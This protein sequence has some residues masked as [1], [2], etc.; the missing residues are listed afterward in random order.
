M[1]ANPPLLYKNDGEHTVS[2]K[3][4]VG[5]DGFG[6]AQF[7]GDLRQ[8]VSEVPN[9][10]LEARA[11]MADRLMGKPKQ[12][13]KQKKRRIMSKKPSCKGS[14]DEEEEKETA[15][16]TENPKGVES[17]EEQGKKL[18]RV[19]YY[20]NS[21]SIGL[22]EKTGLKR[23]LVSFGGKRLGTEEELRLIADECLIKLGQGEEH[24]SVKAWAHKKAKA[25]SC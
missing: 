16:E 24:L 11:L 8:C 3:L 5:P 18:W 6:L 17:L 19:M 20:K 13:R 12:E 1:N 22:K 10:I 2:A 21:N 25:L 9:L 7:D 23:Q 4:E 15:K 14:M